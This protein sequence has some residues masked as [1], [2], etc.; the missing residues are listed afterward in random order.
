MDLVVLAGRV[1]RDVL[2]LRRADGR[3]FLHGRGLAHVRLV[4]A[5]CCRR[6]RVGLRRRVSGQVRDRVSDA[7]I[8]ATRR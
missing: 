3:A 8:S 2:A 6:Q 1:A 4:R 7:A 5:V